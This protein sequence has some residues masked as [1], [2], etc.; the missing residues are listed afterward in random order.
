MVE[1]NFQKMNLVYELQEILSLSKKIIDSELGWEEK[2][3][4]IFSES[5][6]KA[7]FRL[8]DLDY[9]DP[10]TSYEEDVLAFVQALKDKVQDLTL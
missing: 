7:V 6:S 5:I 2:Y 8:I 10:D 9:Y 3:D 1:T 4:L